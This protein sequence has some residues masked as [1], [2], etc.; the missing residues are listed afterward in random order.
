MNPKFNP[1]PSKHPHI[2][3]PRRPR[4]T[5]PSPKSKYSIKQQAPQP[6]GYFSEV[7]EFGEPPQIQMALNEFEFKKTPQS[8]Y[9]EPPEDSYG[10]PLKTTVGETYAPNIDEHMDATVP[11]SNI[12]E[13]S[14][15]MPKYRRWHDF[16]TNHD[17]N[18]AYSNEQKI[19]LMGPKFV[20]DDDDEDISINSYSDIF[21]YSPNK[22]GSS[23]DNHKIAS[24]EFIQNSQKYLN[25]PWKVPSSD[26]AKKNTEDHYHMIVG[27][28][29][30][31]PP[32][33]FVP[34]SNA[35]PSIYFDGFRIFS[36]FV[37]PDPASATMSSYVNYKHSNM[38]FS[39]QN[40]NDAFGIVEK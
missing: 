14:G 23:Y 9:A 17:N 30:A 6:P 31:E 24:N 22:P 5:V 10:T 33:R 34:G 1:S 8:L 29:Y 32:G 2:K 25:K 26:K 15:S 3:K 12:Y 18:Y 4:P 13:H 16:P 36:G 21:R 19:A 11:Y 20:D 7:P 37:K 27:G 38:A 28:Q 39:P 40:L 35:D